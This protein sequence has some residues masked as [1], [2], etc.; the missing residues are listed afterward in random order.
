MKST[1]DPDTI[2]AAWMEDGPIE[3]ADPPRRSIMT[4]VRATPQRRGL[5][6][7]WRFSHMTS[8]FKL[9]A[10]VVAIAAVALVAVYL[11]GRPSNVGPPASPS[12]SP[13]ATPPSFS[14]ES[15]VFRPGMSLTGPDAWAPGLDQSNHVAVTHIGEEGGLLF[16]RADRAFSD[17]CHYA[18]GGPDVNLARG[19]QP[20]IDWIASLPLAASASQPISVTYGAYTGQQIDTTTESLQGCRDSSALHTGIGPHPRSGGYFVGPNEMDRWTVLDVD[21]ATVTIVV[22]SS[23]SDFDAVWADAEPILA[24]I[25]FR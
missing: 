3:L 6:A 7:P 9:S 22:W 25:A 1:H 20:V 15:S 19:V 5:T 23:A 4:A 11:F 2:I 21:G 18:S 24:N 8:A 14:Y 13:S 16:F 12:P 10:G 17:P